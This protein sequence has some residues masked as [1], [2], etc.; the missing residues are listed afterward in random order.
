MLR[1]SPFVRKLTPDGLSETGV[2]A[3]QGW[4]RERDLPGQFGHARWGK[5]EQGCMSVHA[6]LVFFRLCGRRA[7]ERD[8]QQ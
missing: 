3:W 4:Q 7:E 5:G 2:T 8:S 6:I 1:E